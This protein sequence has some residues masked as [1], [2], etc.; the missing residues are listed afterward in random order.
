MPLSCHPMKKTMFGL[1]VVAQRLAMVRSMGALTVPLVCEHVS[2]S[3][4]G[5][6]ATTPWSKLAV[7]KMVT[8]SYGGSPML[9][10]D[11]CQHLIQDER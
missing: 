9:G 3:S 2:P 6:Q 1:I 11:S 8:R 5:V 7:P 10:K 4:L